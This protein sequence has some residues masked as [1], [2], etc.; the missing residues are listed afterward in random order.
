MSRGLIFWI[1]MLIWLIVYLL[2]AFG[3]WAYGGRVSVLVEFIL[4]LLLGWQVYGKP[5]QD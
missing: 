1:I 3:L 2:G 5:I 4:F